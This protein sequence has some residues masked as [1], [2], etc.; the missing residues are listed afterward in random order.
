MN[1]LYKRNCLRLLDFQTYE[2]KHI[3][4]VARIL[5]SAKKNKREIKYLK[6]KKIVLIFEKESTR[7]RCAFEVAAF[8]QGA[9]VTYLGPGSTH[10]GYKESIRDTARVLS[11]M[12]NGIQYRGHSHHAIET[13]AQY[14]EVPVWNGLTERFHP[15]QILA[16]LLTIQ[17]TLPLRKCL[18]DI[19]FAYVGDVRNNIGY[20]LLEAAALFGFDLRLVSPSQFWPKLTFFLKCREQAQKNNGNIICTENI[21]DGVKNVDFIYSDVWISMGEPETKWKTHINLLKKYQVNSKMLNLTKNSNTKVLH[22]LPAF[23]DKDTI[24]G[25]KII[26]NNNLKFGIEITNQVFESNSKIIF[27]QS[28]NRL[29]TIKALMITSLTQNFF[30]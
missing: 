1:S 6:N 8:D 21:E 28:E 27:E 18:S 29:H 16:D 11:R 26:K 22:C 24:M 12:Y 23:H 4:N 19:K 3:I 15:T 9:N 13:L 5:K 7:T 20:T 14:S 30:L 17:E 2:V 25:K 10:L